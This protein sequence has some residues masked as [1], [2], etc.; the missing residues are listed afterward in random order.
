MSTLKVVASRMSPSRGVLSRTALL[1]MAL[2]HH[3]IVPEYQNACIHS[4]TSNLSSYMQPGFHLTSNTEL[5][6]H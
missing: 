2:D 5:L 3:M 1:N 4:G 6:C